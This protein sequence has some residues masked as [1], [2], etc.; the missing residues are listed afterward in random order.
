VA[1]LLAAGIGPIGPIELVVILAIV[2]AIFGAGK[3]AGIGNALGQT[4]RE[5]RVAAREISE[6]DKPVPTTMDSPTKSDAASGDATC[7]NCSASLEIA[8][9][10]CAECGVANSVATEQR[11]T[12]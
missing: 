10:Y 7:T 5:F 3:L 8:A 4:I 9:K 6:I 2:I 1:R 11:H 12:S